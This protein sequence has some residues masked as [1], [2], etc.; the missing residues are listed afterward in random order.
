M[1]KAVAI[2]LPEEIHHLLSQRAAAAG[3]RLD[4]YVLE[5]IEHHL[6]DLHD[7]SV[8]DAARLRLERGEDKVLTAEEFWR[9]MDD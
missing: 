8:A 6:E 1:N 9:G 5:L 7:L 2:D 4:D 3:T